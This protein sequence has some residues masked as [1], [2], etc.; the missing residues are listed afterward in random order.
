[1]DKDKI[2]NIIKEK[3]PQFPLELL[4]LISKYIMCDIVSDCMTM[5]IKR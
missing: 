2:V 1:M 4:D 3:Y 5:G